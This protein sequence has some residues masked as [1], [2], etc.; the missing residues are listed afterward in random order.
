[1]SPLLLAAAAGSTDPTPTDPTPTDPN[2]ADPNATPPYAM[3]TAAP[4][5]VPTWCSTPTADGSGSTV[6]PAVIDFAQLGVP[7]GTWHGWRYWM[8]VTGYHNTNDQL[9]NPHILVSQNGFW[10]QPP[11]GV[12]IPLYDAPPPPRFNSDT[13]LEYDPENDRLVMIYRERQPDLTQQTFIATSSDG[14]TWPAVATALDWDRPNG[15]GQIVSPSI[16]YR[17]V[18]DWWLFGIGRDS[19]KLYAWRASDPL[20]RWHNGQGVGHYRDLGWIKPAGLKPWHL[21]VIW[22]DDTFRA[23]VDCGPLYLAE[24]DGLAAGTWDTSQST[25]AW[26]PNPVIELPASGW[27]SNE[28]YRATFTPHEDGQHYRVWYSAQGPDSWRTGYTQ[29]PRNLWP[30]N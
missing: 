14:T 10:W 23:L 18:G 26:N 3:P 1:M 29:L 9:E 27:D 21:D 25:F 13:D 8:A 4:Y 19:L 6:H 2:A 28:L 5:T 7:G 22:D 15:N 17:G 30:A 11:A 12:R 24:E 20:G 16:V